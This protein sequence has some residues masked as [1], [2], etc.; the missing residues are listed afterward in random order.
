MK[1]KTVQIHDDDDNSANYS[2][3]QPRLII[4]LTKTKEFDTIYDEFEAV[5][6]KVVDDHQADADK[7]AEA[8]HVT[9]DLDEEPPK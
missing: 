8:N 4:H 5:F 7:N 9:S 1:T 3:L 2:R 6:Q